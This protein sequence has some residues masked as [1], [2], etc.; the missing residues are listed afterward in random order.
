MCSANV[1]HITSSVRFPEIATGHSSQLGNL[2]TCHL[3]TLS[4]E[5]QKAAD[6]AD[7]YICA[8]FSELVLIFGQCM[9]APVISAPVRSALVLSSQLLAAPVLSALVLK[10]HFLQ[11]ALN[12][13]R[14]PR[15]IWQGGKIEMRNSLVR[16]TKNTWKWWRANR[17][18]HYTTFS[19]SGFSRLNQQLFASKKTEDIYCTNDSILNSGIDKNNVVNVH[20]CPA[21]FLMPHI[22]DLKTNTIAC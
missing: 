20:P 6:L 22:L 11:P 9:H 19:I 17:D 12:I 13:F 4:P 16:T 14:V 1:L 3:V 15:N 5:L 18:L 10:G 21:G 7:T 8:I 2:T